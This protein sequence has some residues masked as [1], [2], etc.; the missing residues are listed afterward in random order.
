MTAQG[1]TGRAVLGAHW[2]GSG[3]DAAGAIAGASRLGGARLEGGVDELEQR[4]LGSEDLGVDL[5]QEREVS[6][7]VFGE[8]CNGI[9]EVGNSR[10]DVDGLFVALAACERLATTGSTGGNRSR[11][12]RVYS[13]LADWLGPSTGRTSGF[14]SQCFGRLHLVFR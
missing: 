1:L 4:L 5:L 11:S 3:C 7:D 6:D 14:G 9:G 12:R 13:S 10:K 2:C 8:G